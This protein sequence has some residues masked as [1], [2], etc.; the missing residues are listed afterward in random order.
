MFD[1]FSLVSAS[2]KLC[3]SIHK[4]AFLCLIIISTKLYNYRTLKRTTPDS[5]WMDLR[6]K[7]PH[8]CVR[9]CMCEG[10]VRARVRVR[11]V[12]IDHVFLLRH[13]DLL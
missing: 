7:R 11:F 1:V 9:V 4:R 6:C 12:S 8:V 10:C 3:V 5:A 13:Q 2:A